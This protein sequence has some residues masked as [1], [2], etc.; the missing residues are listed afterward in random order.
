MT[1]KNKA[2]SNQLANADLNFVSNKSLEQITDEMEHIKRKDVSVQ[3]VRSDEATA[4]FQMSYTRDDRTTAEV[5][6]RLQRWA[7]NMT[8]V[9]CDGRIFRKKMTYVSMLTRW[10]IILAFAAPFILCPLSYITS[11][12]AQTFFADLLTLSFLVFV[13]V[14]T[15]FGLYQFFSRVLFVLNAGQ[16]NLD[17]AVSKPEQKDR[18][19]LLHFLTEIIRDEHFNNDQMVL[20]NQAAEPLSE[21][22]VMAILQQAELIA[23]LKK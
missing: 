21:E 2:K 12:A 16:R 13:F 8:H 14:G 15:L 9:Y 5:V 6:G 7:G 18:E 3:I 17:Q 10:G 11:G 22:E 19:Q 20:E 4:L 23:R 1:E